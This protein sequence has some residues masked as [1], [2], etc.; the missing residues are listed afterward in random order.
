MSLVG[1]LHTKTNFVQMPYLQELNLFAYYSQAELE[2]YI[3]SFLSCL[4]CL[5]YWFTEETVLNNFHQ[6]CTSVVQLPKQIMLEICMVLSI[7]CQL[8]DNGCD[9]TSTMRYENK[10][11]FLDDLNWKTDLWIMR[12]RY[13]ISICHVGELIDTSRHYLGH[14]IACFIL[15]LVHRF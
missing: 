11:R 9:D 7:G 2:L 13:L 15:R 10:R 4:N 14:H 1:D 3:Y 8:S 12:A 5:L 6:A